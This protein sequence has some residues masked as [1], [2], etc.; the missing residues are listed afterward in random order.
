MIGRI[1]I[2]CRLLHSTLLSFSLPLSSHYC[3][4]IARLFLSMMK[5][6]IVIQMTIVCL[7]GSSRDVC[8]PCARWLCLLSRFSPFVCRRWLLVGLRVSAR[9]LV[10]FKTINHLSKQEVMTFNLSK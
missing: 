7:V 8:V 5:Q 3:L 6:G 9:L 10:T 4:L 2:A 1:G